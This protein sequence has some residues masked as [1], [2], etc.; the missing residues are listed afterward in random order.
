[1]EHRSFIFSFVGASFGVKCPLCRTFVGSSRYRNC[2]E[3]VPREMGHSFCLATLYSSIASEAL[4]VCDTTFVQLPAIEHATNLGNGLWLIQSA[5]SA[6]TL[7][8][9]SS[10]YV[11]GSSF[12]G[13]RICLIT[14]AC[15]MESMTDNIKI[16]SD[17]LSCAHIPLI[18]LQVSLPNP[19][20]S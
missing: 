19:I 9:V 4:A 17:L 15:G 6:V 16:R 18:K 13:C 1:M 5:Q 14:L 12:R 2:S 11:H 20:A 10:S 7:R 8:E 3:S